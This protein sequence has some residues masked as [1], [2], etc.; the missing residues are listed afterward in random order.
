VSFPG[1]VPHEELADWYAASDLFVFPSPADAMGIVLVEAMSV[2]LPCVAVGRYGPREVLT[3]GVTGLLTDFDEEAFA[4][5]VHRL[6]TDPSLRAR[7]GEAGKRRARDYAPEVAARKL[8]EVYQEAAERGRRREAP[9][10]L[11]GSP[12]TSRSSTLTAGSAARRRGARRW[13]V[14]KS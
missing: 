7:M 1:W 9:S 11:G 2:G 6:L 12:W 8:V 3:D 10:Q 4:G 5:A 13:S 14:R